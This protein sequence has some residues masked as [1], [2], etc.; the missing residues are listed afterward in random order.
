[1]LKVHL[2]NISSKTKYVKNWLT[3]HFDYPGDQGCSRCLKYF[4]QRGVAGCT[5]NWQRL[6]YFVLFIFWNVHFRVI[7]VN[8]SLLEILIS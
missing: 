6:R 8:L 1:M 7:F 4:Q 2:T 3:S 5:E